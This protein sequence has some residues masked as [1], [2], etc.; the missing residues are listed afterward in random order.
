MK[1]K[2]VQVHITNDM[3][4]SDRH[5]DNWKWERALML[6]GMKWN[7]YQLRISGYE[8]NPED[9]YRQ[10]RFAMN[11]NTRDEL[12]DARSSFPD[13]IGVTSIS[14][15]EGL[16]MGIQGIEVRIDDNLPDGRV[17]VIKGYEYVSFDWCGR[18]CAE[19]ENN[20]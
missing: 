14:A 13:F 18:I 19:V 17:I 9:Y 12:I 11:A 2:P 5:P 16:S 20:D 7:S 15:K 4:P 10:Y 1:N 3:R 6:L 8:G